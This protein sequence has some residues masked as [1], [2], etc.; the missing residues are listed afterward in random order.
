[1]L[2][3]SSIYFNQELKPRVS[4]N[5][6]EMANLNQKYFGTNSLDVWDVPYFTGF[7]RQNYF[8]QIDHLRIQEFFSLGACMEG[9]DRLFYHLY[10]VRLRLKDPL[11]GELWHK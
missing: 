1:M 10:N 11:P 8:H 6:A 7:V 9:L 3:I 5:Y 2:S 4:R